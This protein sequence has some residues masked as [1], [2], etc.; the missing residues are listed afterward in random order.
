MGLFN[1]NIE[2]KITEKTYE[3]NGYVIGMNSHI[4]YHVTKI[5][6]F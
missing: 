1:R 3:E 5:K 6:L 2:N 4:I